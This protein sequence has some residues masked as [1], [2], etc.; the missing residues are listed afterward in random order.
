MNH[1]SDNRLPATLDVL[2]YH[3]DS[4]RELNILKNVLEQNSKKI[5][6][7]VRGAAHKEDLF[8]SLKN[9]EL[10]HIVLISLDERK[11]ADD[12]NYAII[13]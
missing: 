13:H 10:P 11:I 9:E 12:Q 3:D 1:H 4:D 8:W 2:V 6:Y 5:A 7:S